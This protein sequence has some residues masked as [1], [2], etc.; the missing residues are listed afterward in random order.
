MT[1]LFPKRPTGG[2]TKADVSNQCESERWS[3]GKE[4]VAR[5]WQV[6][7]PDRAFYTV[8]YRKG[9]NQ[10]AGNEPLTWEPAY[11]TV[12]GD[13]PLAELPRLRMK[14]P[15][16]DVAVLRCRLEATAAAKVRLRLEPTEGLRLWLDGAVVPFR[17][18]TE[19]SLSAG[20]HTL[21]LAVS[22][23]RKGPVRCEVEDTPAA[24]GVRFVGGK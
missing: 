2:R 14:A 19:L 15:P 24:A 6:L 1:P 3:V 23:A 7:Q 13:L 9:L 22:G 12:A 10:V 11:S 17:E 20:V 18:A 21:T 8:L 16:L 4:K 5:R